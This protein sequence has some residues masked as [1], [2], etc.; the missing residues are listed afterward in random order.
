MM[1]E[2]QKKGFLTWLNTGGKDFRPSKA[3]TLVVRIDDPASFNPPEWNHADGD[4]EGGLP[5]PK[6]KQVEAPPPRVPRNLV[7]VMRFE[8]PRPAKV[9]SIT[10]Y[11]PDDFIRFEVD[12]AS[13]PANC[14]IAKHPTYKAE[15]IPGKP[16]F[17]DLVTCR[18]PP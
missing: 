17:A 3:P 5:M 4:N 2:L 15:F 7:Y 8:L 1:P 9:F 6:N 13:L 12:K 14:T 10:T 16:V 18:M 11:E